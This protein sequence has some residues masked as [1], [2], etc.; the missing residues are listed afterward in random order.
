MSTLEKI[1][2]VAGGKKSYAANIVLMV[3]AGYM[4][5]TSPETEAKWTALLFLIM[6]VEGI[7]QRLGIK[8]IEK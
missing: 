8:K 4:L 7:F 1:S 3:A 6:G 2:A 5:Y